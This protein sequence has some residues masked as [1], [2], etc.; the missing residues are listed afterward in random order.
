MLAGDPR[1][2]RMVYSLLFSLPGTPVLF[3]GEEIGMGENRDFPGRQSVR[4]PMQWTDGKNGGFSHAPPGRLVAP[5]PGDGYAPQH[6]NVR[7]QRNEEESL[8]A[9]IR[10]LINRY[11]VSH[12][13]GWGTLGILEHDGPGVLVHEVRSDVGHMIALHNFTDVPV[14]LTVQLG[15]LEDGSV[16]LDLH[17]PERIEPDSRG[18]AEFELAPYGFRW[19]RAAPPGD[20]RIG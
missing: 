4:T 16:L 8:L 2:I 12:E 17:G 9:F 6:V 18:R 10:H 11:R 3:Y 5:I 20:S 14:R 1:R 19:V 7:A 13:I 15:E